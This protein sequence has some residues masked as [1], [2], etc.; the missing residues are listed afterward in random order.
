MLS[1]SGYK[2]VSLYYYSS[3]YMYAICGMVRSPLEELG[4][5]VR[6]LTPPDLTTSNNT[7]LAVSYHAFNNDHPMVYIS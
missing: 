3:S 4:P 7:L 2:T 6:I 5:G 1:S